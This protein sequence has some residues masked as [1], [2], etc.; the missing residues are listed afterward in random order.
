[1]RERRGR[2]DLCG[3]QACRRRSD[4]VG[5]A[6][7]CAAAGVRVNAVAPGPTE[8]GM[9]DRFTGGA[10]GKAYLATLIPHKPDRAP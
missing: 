4:Q 6:R 10:D 3:K 9:L 2:L 7:S 8:T 5:G 1:M